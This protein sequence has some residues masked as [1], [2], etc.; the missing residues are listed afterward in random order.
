MDR[1]KLEAIFRD[2]GVRAVK[3]NARDRNALG[4]SQKIRWRSRFFGGFF[5]GYRFPNLH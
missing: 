2:E 3:E 1:F 4:M 5:H